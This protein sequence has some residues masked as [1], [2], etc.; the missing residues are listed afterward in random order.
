MTICN[1]NAYTVRWCTVCDT[2]RQ[3]G[4][5]S[6]PVVVD[7]AGDGF[8]LTDAAGGVWFDLDSDGNAEPLPWTAAGD[9]DAWLA[10]DRN[11]NGRID[12]G[13]EL[14]GNFTPQPANIQPNGFIA[15]AAFDQPSTGGNADGW[16]TA[17]DAIF[18]E[19]RLWRDS[20]HDGVSQ[21]IELIP[22]ATAEVGGISLDYRE[23]RKHDQWGNLF[24]YRAKIEGSAGSGRPGR[25]AYDVFLA[26]LEPPPLN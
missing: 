2:G 25:W 4:S 7:V 6:S 8:D 15:L 12:S 9:D 17:E 5:C 16:I 13:F 1:S 21:A 14:F 20:N 22:L 26:A 3:C 18:A 11:G 24:S 19:L 23:S 10:L